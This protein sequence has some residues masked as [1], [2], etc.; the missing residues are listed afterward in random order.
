MGNEGFLPGGLSGRDVKLT[1]IPSCADVKNEKSYTTTPRYIF[2][3]I[4]DG[5][6]RHDSTLLLFRVL[7][8]SVVAPSG[9]Y[10]E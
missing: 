3:G 1:A 8:V 5:T 9:N 6:T 4:H 7:C 10:N 2:M